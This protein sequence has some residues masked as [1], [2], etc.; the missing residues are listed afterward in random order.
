MAIKFK[1]DKH[2]VCFPTKLLAGNGGEHIYNIVID[3]D[4][5]NGTIVSRGEYVSFDQYKAGTAPAT[6]EG[7]ITEQAANGNWYVE[8]V[9]PEDAILIYEVPVIAET[10]DARFTDIANFYN[11][12][13]TEDDP[14]RTKTVRGYALAKGDVYELSEDAFDKKP[15]PGKKV[16]ISGQKHV[17]A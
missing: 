3:E 7:I 1:I 13:N 17:V 6:Y 16:T 15:T 12:V 14:E 11:A 9:K 8:V 5:D 2:H 10:Y 4:T